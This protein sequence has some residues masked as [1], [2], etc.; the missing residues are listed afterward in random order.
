MQYPNTD[1]NN[2]LTK[3]RSGISAIMPTENPSALYNMMGNPHYFHSSETQGPYLPPSPYYHNF[4]NTNTFPP[5][6]GEQQEN[7]MNDHFK[8]M[9]ERQYEASFSA[10][11][12]SDLMRRFFFSQFFSPLN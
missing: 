10:P 6:S 8:M 2:G 1:S 4:Q 7:I 12:F 5:P 3:R 11:T 9:N